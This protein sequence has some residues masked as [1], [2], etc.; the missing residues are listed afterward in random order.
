MTDLGMGKELKMVKALGEA[1][2]S[3]DAYPL[4]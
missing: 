1:V 2:Q 4:L 3:S